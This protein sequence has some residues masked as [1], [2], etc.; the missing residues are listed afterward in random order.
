MG[1]FCEGDP[2]KLLFL[3]F[4]VI[5]GLMLQDVQID[6]GFWIQ[7]VDNLMKILTK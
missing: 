6:K 1:D 3:Y 2:Y 4:S 5:S 7:E